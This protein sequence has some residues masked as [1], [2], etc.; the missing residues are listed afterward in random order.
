[1][2]ELSIE[3]KYLSIV[4]E[5]VITFLNDEKVKIILFGSRAR[6]D[7]QRC[8]DVDIGII[9]VGKFNEDRITLLKEKVE[10]LNIPYKVEIVNLSEV[11]GEFKREVMKD[12]VVWKD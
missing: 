12:A 5:V 11:S 9:P 4:K 3:K 10:D 7:N 2:K 1:M 8:S 6:G